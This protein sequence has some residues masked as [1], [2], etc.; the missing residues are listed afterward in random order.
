MA[1]VD[2]ENSKSEQKTTQDQTKPELKDS[3]TLEALR[4]VKDAQQQ[5]GLRHDDYH[6][7][8]Q[9]CA[10]RLRRVRKS[11]HFP[12]GNMRKVQPKKVTE[13]HLKDV[14]FLLIPLFE[15]ERAWAYA[16][17]LKS[18]SNTE[19]RKKYHKLSRL[20]KAVQHASLLNA[21][22]SAKVCDA[23]SKL[24]AEAYESWMRASYEFELE[25]W[26]EAVTGFQKAQTIYNRLFDAITD[27][28]KELYK[29]RCD[30]ITPILRYCEYNIGD[31]SAMEE[32]RKLRMTQGGALSSQ[33]DEL[34]EKTKA[35]QVATLSEVSW[36]G[37]II[38]IKSETIRVHL[39]NVQELERSLSESE[40][41]EAKL[42]IYES[43]LKD[44]IDSAAA[45]KEESKD[46]P[47]FR[48]IIRGQ[49]IE[50]RVPQSVHLY[51]YI[52][53]KRLNHNIDRYLLMINQAKQNLEVPSNSDQK[54]TK[55]HELARLYDTIVQNANDITTL[56]GLEEDLELKR[57]CKV[58]IAVFKTYR[59]YY[60]A[61]AYQNVSKWGETMALY[62]LV[63]VRGTKALEQLENTNSDNAFKS[64]ILNLINEADAGKSVCRVSKVSDIHDLNKRTKKL[65]VKDLKIPL[66]ERLDLF[67]EDRSL[68][69]D[70]VNLTSLPP[71]FEPVACKPLFFDLALSLL[72]FPN[73]D[74]QIGE[75]KSAAAGGGIGGMIKSLWGWGK[76]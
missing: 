11:L 23:R 22:C 8:R 76:K 45:L 56:P 26:Q 57:E 25:K 73:L 7:Y 52:M 48:S 58:K 60:A 3:L 64:D 55:P 31:K 27:D 34:I 44:L 59:C 10:R 42:S 29:I 54:K 71:D 53:Y 21:L 17:A 41:A 72:K 43:L 30:E 65:S 61:R 9:Y 4:I 18:E 49:Q 14:K 50:G 68:T 37:K 39:L 36:R 35:K 20:R 46:D 67:G 51:S 6:R 28:S 5:H 33:L 63:E 75:K 69:G 66:D 40:N 38:P 70:Q 24:E 62:D 47:T 13:D 19:P 16:V 74:D 1:D 12:Q 15:A 32:L 2:I